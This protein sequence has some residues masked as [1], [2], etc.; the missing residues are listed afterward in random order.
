METLLPAFAYVA[1]SKKEPDKELTAAFKRIIE[2]EEYQ[3]AITKYIRN[4]NSNLA[5]T[6]TIGEIELLTKLA[7]I[8]TPKEKAVAGSLF[9]PYSGL[10]VAKDSLLHFNIKGFSR[11][12]WDFESSATENTKGRYLSYGQI[13][14]FDLKTNTNLSIHKKLTSTGIIF[15]ELR[16][17]FCQ[18]KY[19]KIK[20]VQVQ[21]IVTSQMKHS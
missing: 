18:I 2:T 4:V 1:L 5:Y 14:Y 10:L 20:A 12:I 19:Y 9:M 7:S 3:Q 13:E 15:R 16:P 17:K 6:S 11:Y 21:G 8:S